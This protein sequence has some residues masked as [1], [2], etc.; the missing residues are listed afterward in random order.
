[1]V[2]CPGLL[3]SLQNAHDE[4]RH[5]GIAAKL[6]HAGVQQTLVITCLYDGS[7]SDKDQRLSNAAGTINCK[8]AL[9]TASLYT[10]SLWLLFRFTF[11]TQT[12][13]LLFMLP[14]PIPL[15]V[16]PGSR[17][18]W[19]VSCLPLHESAEPDSRQFS[20]EL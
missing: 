20:A 5:G 13:S 10:D 1:M 15:P 4:L 19:V 14:D 3:S 16:I 6:R 7:L 18:Q 9:R 17:L 8:A 11:C 12:L 2:S